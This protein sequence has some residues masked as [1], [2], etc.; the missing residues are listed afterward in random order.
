VF[1]TGTFSNSK[2][3]FTFGYRF[4]DEKE[5]EGDEKTEVDESD[6]KQSDDKSNDVKQKLSSTHEEVRYSYELD[7]GRFTIDEG[8]GLFPTY[9]SRSQHRGASRRQRNVDRHPSCIPTEDI[10]KKSIARQ[11]AAKYYGFSDRQEAVRAAERERM[12]HNG[13]YQKKRHRAG[14]TG[15]RKKAVEQ[16]DYETGVTIQVSCYVQWRR[17]LDFNNCIC[18]CRPLFLDLR[19]RGF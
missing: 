16:F 11:A 2:K 10:N 1:V 4:R 12:V 9:S 18:F 19:P 14:V 5:E 7:N 8:G 15:H 17:E 3:E 13:G 6:K